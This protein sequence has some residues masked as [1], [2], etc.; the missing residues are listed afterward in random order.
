MNPI[1]TQKE[2]MSVD[3]LEYLDAYIQTID[4]KIAETNEYLAGSKKDGLEDIP[5]EDHYIA[6]L[7]ILIS[8]LGA[9]T[10]IITHYFS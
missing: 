5:A 7:I 2:P 8:W 3:E 6:L 1:K 4:K 9:A 10:I